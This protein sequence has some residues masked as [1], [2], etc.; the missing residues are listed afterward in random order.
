MAKEIE[1]KYLVN[2]DSFI[3]MATECHHIVQGYLSASPRATV[4]IR[5]LDDKAYLTIK[6]ITDG[7][8]RN[9]WE[10]VIPID[11]A[12]EMLQCHEGLLIEK[13]RYIVP[14]EGHC[15]EID[16]FIGIN[17]PE[18]CGTPLVMAEIELQHADEQ[19][20]L[21][22]FIGKEVTTDARYYNSSIAK[23]A[24]NNRQ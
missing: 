9:E 21:P 10:Y 17:D 14:Y 18:S 16:K 2:S 11:D 7:C 8:S 4:R 20:E 1:R 19:F 12:N 5:I 24:V 15:W 23:S 6:G 22:P 13:Y 3:A